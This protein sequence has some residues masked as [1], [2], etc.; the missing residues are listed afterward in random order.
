MSNRKAKARS[1]DDQV[2][3]YSTSL[4]T[5]NAS[6]TCL[7]QFYIKKCQHFQSG[8]RKLPVHILNVL[9]TYN[10]T[11]ATLKTAVDGILEARTGP[12]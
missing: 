6:A 3:P 10:F 1:N 7:M 9:S 11:Q 5:G 2:R 4:C 12:T 8:M